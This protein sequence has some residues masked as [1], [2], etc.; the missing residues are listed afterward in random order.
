MIPEKES[1]LKEK[2][3]SLPKEKVHHKFLHRLPS[4]PNKKQLLIKNVNT[5]KLINDKICAIE[6]IR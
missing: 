6:S 3:E 1:S 5:N 2:K 4:N